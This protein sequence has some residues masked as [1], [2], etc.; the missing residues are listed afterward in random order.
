MS[1][2]LK[3]IGWHCVHF[4]HWFPK[5]WFVDLSLKNHV[6]NSE[7]K[8][9]SEV[10]I[11]KSRLNHVKFRSLRLMPPTRW[12]ETQNL[13]VGTHPEHPRLIFS[14]EFS[15]SIGLFNLR[16]IFS[17]SFF[18]WFGTIDFFNRI[19]FFDWTNQS[20]RLIFSIGM[21]DFSIEFGSFRMI[22]SIDVDWSF[23]S[24]RSIFQSKFK[25]DVSCRLIVSIG[26]VFVGSICFNR[27]WV[28]FGWLFNRT[29]QS[30]RCSI[31][32]ATSRGRSPDRPVWQTTTRGR[33]SDD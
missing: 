2:C 3:N 1:G 25:F 7:L 32:Q 21:I 29:N 11:W 26:F 19:Q 13:L 8:P 6:A 12:H 30:K 14:I 16:L 23:Q 24:E 10:W 20:P 27:I 22:C 33:L 4:S 17:I 9:D 18:D 31:W 15:V 28:L 5:S